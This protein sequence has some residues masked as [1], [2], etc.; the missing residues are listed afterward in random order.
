MIWSMPSAVGAGVAFPGQSETGLQSRLSR[1]TDASGLT[2]H[3][4]ESSSPDRELSL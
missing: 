1:T 2:T 4:I 3:P